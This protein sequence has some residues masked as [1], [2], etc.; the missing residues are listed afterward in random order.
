MPDRIAYYSYA[1]VPWTNKAQRLFNEMDLPSAE[2]KVALYIKG[3]ERLLHAGYV[4]I[5]M[6]HFSLPHDELCK[7]RTK[8]NL[9]RSF[10]GYTT[11]YTGLLIGLGVS[12]ISDAGIAFA[13]NEKKLHDYYE[14]IN[15]GN[16]PVTKGYFLND[17]DG[18]FRRHIL[19]MSCK[20]FTR[21]NES[22][23]SLL[24]HYTFP[25]LQDL[26]ADGLVVYNDKGCNVTTEG[27]YF[28][29]NICS[30]FDLHLLR[31]KQAVEKTRYSK[32]M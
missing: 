16:L 27:R 30:A 20:G 26:E 8:G 6:D 31:N 23:L 22:E 19:N 14:I 24:K 9:H 13:Q 21:F 3:K 12:S 15:G 2:E 5:G 17:E 1:H 25:L 32:A 7:A 29:R 11:Q 10:M 18:I 4:E 28:I